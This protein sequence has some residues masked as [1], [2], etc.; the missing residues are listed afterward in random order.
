M[1]LRSFGRR[2]G[3]LEGEAPGLHDLLLK[4]VLVLSQFA[5]RLAAAR[6]RSLIS[7]VHGATGG[8]RRTTGSLSESNIN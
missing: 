1:L 4:V 6:G 3:G 7:H 8:G 5:T 2:E